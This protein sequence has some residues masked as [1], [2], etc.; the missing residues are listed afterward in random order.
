MAIYLLK[1]SWF[2]RSLR[3]VLSIFQCIVVIYTKKLPILM[4]KLY[5]LTSVPDVV[6]SVTLNYKIP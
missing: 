3:K 2:S 1:H 5:F 4:F 6:V